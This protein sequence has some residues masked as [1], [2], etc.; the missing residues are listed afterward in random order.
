MNSVRIGS[1]ICISV[2]F[3]QRLVPNVVRVRSIFVRRELFNEK[4]VRVS[5]VDGVGNFDAI[6]FRRD[7]F[8]EPFESVIKARSGVSS[9]DLLT[10]FEFRTNERRDA[11]DDNDDFVVELCVDES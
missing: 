4:S 11:N 5:S 10:L 1:M 9:T 3:G 6:D 7:F 2:N 8:I